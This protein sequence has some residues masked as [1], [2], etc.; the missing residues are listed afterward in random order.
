MEKESG[1]QEDRKN[2]RYRLKS[3]MPE[4]LREEITTYLNEVKDNLENYLTWATSEITMGDD[5]DR[6][7][8]VVEDTIHRLMTISFYLATFFEDADPSH[9]LADIVSEVSEEQTTDTNFV[10][11]RINIVDPPN[12]TRH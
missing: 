3:R 6:A 10:S 9:I 7:A 4:E 2:R 5:P 11:G 1:Y 12:R 8:E